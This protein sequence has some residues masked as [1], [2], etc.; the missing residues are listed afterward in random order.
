MD[1]NHYFYE[2]S[3]RVSKKF[4]EVIESMK[5]MTYSLLASYIHRDENSRFPKRI[6]FFR[7]GVSEGMFDTT[8]AVE[9]KGIR[10]A[11]YQI[12]PSFKPKIT[13]IVA[14]KRHSTRLFTDESTKRNVPSGTL[15][16][17]RITHPC[18]FDYYLCSH[19]SYI[20]TSRPTHYTVILDENNL[21]ADI[22]YNLTFHLC[23]T[24]AP[25]TRSISI[26]A[27]IQYAHLSAKRTRHHLLS[28]RDREHWTPKIHENIKSNMYFI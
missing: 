1:S 9:V 3:I 8:L 12:S 27:P 13:V 25:A 4:C 28:Q 7:D 17:S 16:D 18:D 26:P 24:Y 6:F 15:V 23:H 11:C 20:G 14:Q 21:D 22:L 10:D 5:E 19:N 2:C